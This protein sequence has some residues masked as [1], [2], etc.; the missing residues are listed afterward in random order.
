MSLTQPSYRALH[1]PDTRDSDPFFSVSNFLGGLGPSCLTPDSAF[2][3]FSFFHPVKA[4]RA[5]CFL[6][7]F[8]C[9]PEFSWKSV[10][11]G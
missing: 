1:H 6:T 4:L 9:A 2:S 7:V 11:V 5:S 8:H 3:P 10:T